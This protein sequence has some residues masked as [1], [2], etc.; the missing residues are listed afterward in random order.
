MVVLNDGSLVATYSGRRNSGGTFT[1]SS[2]VFIYNPTLNSWNDVSDVGMYYWTKDIVIDPNDTT[3][4]IWY[5]GVFSGWGGAPN[6]LG[7]LYKTT[8]RGANWTKLTGSTLDRVTSCTFNPN[9]ANEIYI[10]TEVQGLWI[11]SDINSG[12]PTFNVVNSYPFRQPERVFF[13]PYNTFEIWVTSFGN[14]MKVGDLGPTAGVV[15]FSEPTF[16][17]YPNPAN[18]FVNIKL[19]TEDPVYIDL[20][21][22][23]G[24]KVAGY[25]LKQGVNIVDVSALANGIY[26]VGV[27]GKYKKIL[28]AH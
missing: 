14:G 15:N 19:N 2:G 6:G 17:I 28:V 23:N 1:A 10:T 20:L 3:Q 27:K 8:N 18:N 21:D 13:N 24:K 25:L 22:I 11:S 4:N 26:T 12:A 9:D 16:N 7:G 5:T